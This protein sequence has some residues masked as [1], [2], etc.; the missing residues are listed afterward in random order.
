[1]NNVQI[2]T[3]ARNRLADVPVGDIWRLLQLLK[4]AREMR[5]NASDQHIAS[6]LYERLTADTDSAGDGDGYGDGGSYA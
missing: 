5:V 1:M 2:S 3:L 6:V 4:N